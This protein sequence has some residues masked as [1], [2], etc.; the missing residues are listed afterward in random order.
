MISHQ[1]DVAIHFPILMATIADLRSN[2]TPFPYITLLNACLCGKSDAWQQLKNRADGGDTIAKIYVMEVYIERKYP[3]LYNK[4]E[5]EAVATPIA[6]ALLPWLRVAA[7]GGSNLHAIHG[8][9]VCYENALGTEM[10]KKEAAKYYMVA[11]NQGHSRA[12]SNLGFM[13]REGHGV[14]KSKE[15][16]LKWTRLAAEQGQAE[17]QNMLGTL[18][19]SGKGSRTAEAK[20]QALKWFR[21]AAEQGY[22][23]AK[24]NMGCFYRDGS[25]GLA[26]DNAEAARWGRLCVEQY[27]GGRGDPVKLNELLRLG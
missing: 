8:L 26:V 20:V 25:L 18:L 23:D 4:I 10:D 2:S 11:A 5:A 9:A 19:L 3:I 1:E 14:R 21:L 22:A 27:E 17:P 12:Q 6:I 24:Y 13:Y 16:D 15:K 7:A